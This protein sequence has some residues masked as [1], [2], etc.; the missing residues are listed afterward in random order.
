MVA[1]IAVAR[2][3]L[4]VDGEHLPRSRPRRSSRSSD[5]LPGARGAG[6]LATRL[7]WVSPE[8]RRKGTPAALV[9]AVLDWAQQGYVQSVELWVTETNDAARRRYGVG[10]VDSG[11]RQPLPSNRALSEI[12]MRYPSGNR[13]R[14]PMNGLSAPTLF[15]PALPNPLDPLP[16]LVID[17]AHRPRATCARRLISHSVRSLASPE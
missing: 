15:A 6:A 17:L 3:P 16:L 1:R 11:A 9:Q 12:G 8:R 4:V 14:D 7:M 13:W 5:R 10:F 2:P